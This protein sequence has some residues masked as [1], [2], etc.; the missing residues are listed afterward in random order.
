MFFAAKNKFIM[1]PNQL[2]YLFEE[3]LYIY[4]NYKIFVL[5]FHMEKQVFLLSHTLFLND[6]ERSPELLF[7]SRKDGGTSLLILSKSE[8]RW[9]FSIYDISQNLATISQR[10][11]LPLDEKIKKPIVFTQ[12]N[13]LYIVD[14]S[15][16][17]GQG[18]NLEE[19]IE[20]SFFFQPTEGKSYSFICENKEFSPDYKFTIKS[21]IYLQGKEQD[22]LWSFEVDQLKSLIS[23]VKSDLKSPKLL[24]KGLV[25]SNVYSCGKKLYVLSSCNDSGKSYL[26]KYDL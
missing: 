7:F 12:E 24:D 17:V 20:K 4:D 18:F 23:L 13:G 10:N 5:T 1:K 14:F 2:L 15:Q 19:I 25:P 11:L 21:K 6:A 26:Q 8:S 22:K 16:N 9:V 3:N